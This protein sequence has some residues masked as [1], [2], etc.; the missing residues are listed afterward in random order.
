MGAQGGA[1]GGGDGGEGGGTGGMPT[2]RSGG[3]MSGRLQVRPCPGGPDTHPD[4]GAWHGSRAAN[5]TPWKI[6][7]EG[8]HGGGEHAVDPGPPGRPA[9]VGNPGG[10]G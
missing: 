10:A 3:M 2:G 4:M 9:A 8:I 5:S 6:G 7:S 1:G